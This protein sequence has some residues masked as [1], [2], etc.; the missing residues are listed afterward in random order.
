MNSTK[1]RGHL[2][3][4]QRRVD[5]DLPGL[6]VVDAEANRLAPAPPGHAPPADA[7]PELRPGR[8]ARSA[9]SKISSRWKQRP[10]RGEAL[11][12]GVALLA[13]AAAARRWM[14]SSSTRP[15]APLTAPGV[16]GHR[17]GPPAP[18][19]RGTC[20]AAAAERGG[21]GGSDT[22]STVVGDREPHLELGAHQVGEPLRQHAR[23]G[24]RLQT[25]GRRLGELQGRRLGRRGGGRRREGR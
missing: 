25:R 12:G 5:A 15:G 16:V 24:H 13:D 21:A 9:A 7:A 14:K 4:V 6:V 18:A 11:V 3:V 8:S 23:L 1:K 22:S 20:G 17:A 2:R 10:A 19:R